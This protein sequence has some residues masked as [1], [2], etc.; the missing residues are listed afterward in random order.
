MDFIR[1]LLLF[2]PSGVGKSTLLKRLFAEFPDKF[3]FSVSRRS[4]SISTPVFLIASADTTRSPRPGE[5]NGKDYHFVNVDDFKS[6]ISDGA[7]IEYAE[8]SG[9]FYGTSFATVDSVQQQGRRCI[10]DIEVQV[11]RHTL[12]SVLYSVVAGRQTDQ[13]DEA[14]SRLL[15]YIA[16]IDDC[17]QRAAS[18]S[19]NGNG[20][21]GS[22]TTGDGVERD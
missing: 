13:A 6:L 20:G 22:E 8:F 10:L 16:A 9:N 11:C 12:F 14:G 2:G 17:T 19:R 3:G 15:F 7:F 4:T 1:P 5:S 21:V 18:G